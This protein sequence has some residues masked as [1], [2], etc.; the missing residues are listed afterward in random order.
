MPGTWEEP[1]A[2]HAAQAG[3]FLG[4]VHAYWID[5]CMSYS[6]LQVLLEFGRCFISE[7]RAR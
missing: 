1:V 6:V 4:E 5:Y 7:G 2:L 3:V